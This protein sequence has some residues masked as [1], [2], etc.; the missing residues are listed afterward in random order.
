MFSNQALE[1]RLEMKHKPV[2]GWSGSFGVQTEHVRFS[3]LSAESGE[4]ATVPVTVS[5]THAAFLVEERDFGAAR[6]NAGARVESVKREPEG[7]PRR[8]FDLLSYS[9]GAIVPLT[10][11]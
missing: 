1:T 8:S 10:R 11:L 7:A 3:G 6:V 5:D 4:S 9:A 2:A